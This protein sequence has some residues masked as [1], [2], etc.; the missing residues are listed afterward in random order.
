MQFAKRIKV[1]FGKFG[2]RCNIGRVSDPKG[3]LSQQLRKQRPW[4]AGGAAIFLKGYAAAAARIFYRLYL[5]VLVG[6]LGKL[7]HPNPNFVVA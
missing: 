3:S 1:I 2:M 7:L 5:F 6:A 4:T